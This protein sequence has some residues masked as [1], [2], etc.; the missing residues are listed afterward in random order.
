MRILILFFLFS[1]VIFAQYDST[2]YD[3]IK[4]TYQRSFDK[5]ILSH[6][7][8]SKNGEK[9]NAALLSISH[10]E[11]TSFVPELLKLDLLKYGSEVCFA[12]GQI[13]TCNQSLNFLWNYLH[14]SP[15]PNQ[16]PKIFFAIGKIGDENDLN[17]LVKFYNSFENSILPPE[18]ISEAILQFQ[19]QGIKNDN[20]LTILEK[21]ILNLQSNESRVMNAMFVLSRL[22]SSKNILHKFVDI[23]SEKSSSVILKQF[24]LINLQRLKICPL[25]SETIKNILAEPNDLIRIEAAKTSAYYNFNE[26]TTEVFKTF[27]SLLEDENLNVA[28]ETAKSLRKVSLTETLPENSP[29]NKILADRINSSQNEILKGEL[30]LTYAHQ[31]GSDNFIS[32]LITERNISDNYIAAYLTTLPFTDSTLNKILDLYEKHNSLE[33]KIL[34][35]KN[36]MSYSKLNSPRID[37]LITDK[38][39]GDIAPLISIAADGLD[40]IFIVKNQ[41]LL[42]KIITE[43]IDKYLNDPDFLEAVMSLTNLSKKVDGK[44][45]N[46]IIIKLNSSNLYSIKKFTTNKSGAKLNSTKDLKMFNDIWKFSFKYSKAF[47]RTEKGNITIEFLSEAA[48]ISVGNFCKLAE[49]NFYSGIIFHR[50]V[51][52]FV[53]QAGDPTGTGWG[54]PGYDIISEFSDMNFETGYVGMASAGKDTE[55]SQFF[56]MQGSHPHLNGRYTIFAKVI[57]GMDVVNNITEDDKIISIKL[58]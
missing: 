6:Y 2:M 31:F 56:I 21:D 52:G 44:F 26:D 47:F 29:F 17:K 38:L 3:L 16:Y 54:G 51:P 58:E 49:E 11:D 20:C 34:I 12:L 10:S 57:E 32:K 53:I 18:G 37:L 14:S 23:V 46:D 33:E 42:K 45:Y 36:I 15:P 25:S 9:I 5:K 24:A 48:P 55:S 28:I 41:N 30:F 40:S 8:L 39:K 1:K 35:F 22:G 7:L 4:T 43:Q 50:V 13:G 19:I 27:I